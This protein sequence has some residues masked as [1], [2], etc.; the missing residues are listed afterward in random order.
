[1]RVRPGIEVLLQKERKSLSGARVGAVVHPASVL[2]DLS[3]TAD[4]LFNVRDFKLVALFGPQHGARGDKQ[5]N[6]VESEFYL[7]PA[8]AL[9]VHS[10][11]GKTRYPTE[12]MLKGLDV[13]VFDLQDVGTRVYTFIHT[14]AYCMQACAQHNKKM[15]VLDRPNPIGGQLTEGNLL[16]LEYR[17]FV[18]L[19][20]IPMRHG[21][22]VG[23]MALLLNSAYRIGC[24]LSV[25]PMEGWTRSMWFDQTGLPWIM[26][27]PN[28]PTLDSATV[29]PGT[30]LVEG[31]CLSEGRGTTRPFEFVG[32]PFI[33]SQPFAHYLNE[34]GLA[35]VH[36]RPACFLPTFQ[37]W[38]GTLC[39]GVQIHVRSR[40]LFEPYLA[41]IAILAAAK[42]MY[43][44][45]FQWRRPPYEYEYE[46]MPIEI[47]CGGKNVPRLIDGG[48][49]LREI[50]ETWQ[51]ELNGFREKRA[52]YLLYR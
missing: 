38:A 17:S 32:A 50:K 45:D 33:R 6:M 46:K 22:T 9:P 19:Y 35:G 31:T 27:S 18:G 25:V 23:E 51:D 39:G 47:L 7:D 12:E 20:P 21:M 29:Y 41:G 14:M 36:F 52:P 44:Q 26:P 48:A 5:D 42:S 1:M 43:P 13:L 49:S 16:E 8:T 24:D 4:A 28:M 30:V 37:K 10:L 34:L 2:A 40:E 3:H 15:I 11:Y